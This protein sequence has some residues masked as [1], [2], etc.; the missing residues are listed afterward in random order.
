MKL[1]FDVLGSTEES[2]GMRLHATQIISAWSLQFPE[3]ELVVVGP[4]WASESFDELSNVSVRQWPNEH[5]ISRFVGQ[6]FVTAIQCLIS[7]PQRVISLSPIVSPLVTRSRSICFEHD[8][9]HK[10]VADEFG[11]GQHMYRKLWELSAA[12]AGAVVCIS[13]KAERET[14]VHVRGA[15]TV[16]IPNGYDHARL[17]RHIGL[18]TLG[19][20]KIVTFGHHNNKRPE[21]VIEAFATMERGQRHVALTVLGAKGEYREALR[22]RTVDLGIQDEVDFPGFVTSAEYERVISSAHVVVLASSDEGF[23]LPV[24]EAQYFGIPVIVTT[25]SGLVDIHGDSVLAAEPMPVALSRVLDGALSAG[26]TG[27]QAFS[28]ERSWTRVSER[29]RQLAMTDQ[30]FNAEAQGEKRR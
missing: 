20:Q 9:R 13:E 23:G 30:V 15:R 3:D 22:R 25:D 27:V 21:L 19:Q 1:L 17:W 18:R 26:V 6:V 29:L 5:V 28:T 12:R 2:G 8:W 10:K 24:A 4:K 16:V 11:F 7:R 14:L